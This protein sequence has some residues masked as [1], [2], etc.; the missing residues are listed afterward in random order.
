MTTT[1]QHELVID[2]QQHRLFE[3]RLY[4]DLF[5]EQSVGPEDSSRLR[6]EFGTDAAIRSLQAAGFEFD[7]C[8][9]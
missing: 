7:D 2:G 5:P 1:E 4:C 3:G 8:R 6:I 9:D